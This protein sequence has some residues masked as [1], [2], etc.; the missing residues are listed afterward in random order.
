MYVACDLRGVLARC[1]SAP[2]GFFSHFRPRGKLA[3]HGYIMKHVCI[4]AELRGG[5]RRIKRR[6][7]DHLA[8]DCVPPSRDEQVTRKTPIFFLHFN[9]LL[10]FFV[11][12]CFVCKKMARFPP[13]LESHSLFLSHPLSNCSGRSSGSRSSSRSTTA[14]AGA[15]YSTSSAHL[16]SAI[17][18]TAASS[19]GGAGRGVSCAEMALLHPCSLPRYAPSAGNKR[20]N[21]II[22]YNFQRTLYFRPDRNCEQIRKVRLPSADTVIDSWNRVHLLNARRGLGLVDFAGSGLPISVATWPPSAERG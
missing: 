17:S 10:R 4:S 20:N 11:L 7:A 21:A 3:C 16:S 8:R 12:F 1:Y 9:K 6:L 19:A 18:L 22:I 2:E 15:I 13:S 14:A 5:V